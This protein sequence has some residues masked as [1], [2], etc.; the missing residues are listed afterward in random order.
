M[1]IYDD[2]H[3]LRKYFNHRSKPL[4]ET[5]KMKYRADLKIYTDWCGM[6]LHELVEEAKEEQR[7]R[8]IDNVLFECDIENCK[9]SERLDSF[10]YYEQDRGIAPL[11][12][13]TRISNIRAFYRGMGVKQ[14]PRRINTKVE[15]SFTL[16][17]RE[18]ISKSLKY[19][20]PLNTAMVTFLA[21]TGVRISDCSNFTINDYIESL[22]LNGLDELVELMFIDIEGFDMLGYWEF[23]PQKTQ[24][25]ICQVCNTP[26]SN[27]YI[28]EYLKTRYI[29][30]GLH[31]KEHLFLTNRLNKITSTYFAYVC[32]RINMK[33]LDDETKELKEQHTQ[34]HITDYEYQ[35]RLENISKFHAHGLRKYFISTISSLCG[36]LRILLLMEG[37]RSIV[38]T[39]NSYVRISEETIREEYLKFVSELTF[40]PVKVEMLTDKRITEYEEKIRLQDERLEVLESFID[41]LRKFD[42]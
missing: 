26:E 14:L 16:L 33:L 37:H 3:I 27:K 31:P 23:R 41:N 5:T 12:L 22:H 29:K 4:A 21:S 35:K 18:K 34:G 42:Y 38:S 28:L 8:I 6:T 30:H 7:T 11:T 39:D 9:L 40:S 1:T 10:F 15:T 19:C 20:N 2:E 36:N 17:T 13:E 25:N 32:Q 24:S